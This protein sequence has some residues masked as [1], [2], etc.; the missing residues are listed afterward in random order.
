MISEAAIAPRMLRQPELLTIMVLLVGAL[1]LK[2]CPSNQRKMFT[3]LGADR[4]FWQILVVAGLGDGT[5][6][7]GD[8]RPA[9]PSIPA[10]EDVAVR[11][12]HD[13][14]ESVR[15]PIHAQGF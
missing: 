4:R 10:V 3:R 2:I 11:R 13:Q 14:G 9:L 1:W 12:T 15:P 6:I 7:L 8:P 5:N